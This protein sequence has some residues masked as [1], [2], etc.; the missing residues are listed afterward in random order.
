MSQNEKKLLYVVVQL[1]EPNKRIIVPESFIF[2]LC[3]ESLKNVGRNP[4]HQYLV[5]WSNLALGDGT[6]EPDT[7]CKP[8]FHLPLSQSYPPEELLEACYLAQIK[9]FFGKCYQF[10]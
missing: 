4:N 3:E 2:D 6:A 7:T 5:Y 10:K 9:M 8:K 1:L